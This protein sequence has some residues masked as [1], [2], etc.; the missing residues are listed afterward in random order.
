MARWHNISCEDCGTD[1]PVCEDW[2]NP[3][4]LCNSC[5]AERAAQWHDVR[6]EECGTAMRLHRDWEN[7]P[8]LCKPCREAKAAEWYDLKCTDCGTTVRVHRDWDHPP[9]YC[10]SCKT[11]RDAEWYERKMRR[12]R[13]NHADSPRL[14]PAPTIMQVPCKA[15]HDAKWYEVH[16]TDCGTAI[17]VNREWDHPPKV[18]KSCKAKR[19]AKWY[20]R[21]CKH[22]GRSIKIN[23]EWPNPPEYHEECAWLLEKSCEICGRD[24][25]I[26]RAWEHPPRS[27]K[28]CLAAYKPK[29]IPCSQC[30]KG[31]AVSTAI[32]LRC[33]ERGWDL[34][35]PLRRVQTR[36]LAHQGRHRRPA[37]S[38]SIRPLRPRSNNEA[39]SSHR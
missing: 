21:S 39:S 4:S 7:P 30:G 16:C 38:V 13:D 29:E 37:R 2:D 18:C 34:P 25:K 19:D 28:E 35:A 20:E 5:K 14:G 23:R 33:K 15:K 12:L 24:M 10:K 31:F 32:Q 17:R 1:V 11:A 3:P 22:C 8:R 9:K 36:F 26:H 27:H 6:C